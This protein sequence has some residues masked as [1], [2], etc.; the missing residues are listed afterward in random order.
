MSHAAFVCSKQNKNS[1]PEKM[2]VL[3]CITISN[4]KVLNTYKYLRL[5]RFWKAYRSICTRLF[6]FSIRLWKSKKHFM[7]LE[8]EL[9][10]QILLSDSMRFSI[11]CKTVCRSVMYPLSSILF[12]IMVPS[13]IPEDH[14]CNPAQMSQY[15]QPCLVHE[16]VINSDIYIASFSLPI[17]CLSS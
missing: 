7:R 1:H 6:A 13:P 8:L 12:R 10:L 9:E 16:W 4:I 5:G 3:Y 15:K 14:W 11:W 2:L 17:M